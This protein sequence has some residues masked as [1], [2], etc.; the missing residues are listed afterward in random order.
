MSQPTIEDLVGAYLADVY[1]YALRLTGN[2]A[3]AE[4]LTQQTF[5]TAQEKLPQLRDA[6]AARPWLWS[7]ARRGFLADRRRKAPV[8]AADLSEEPDRST[9]DVSAAFPVDREALERALAQ[10][11]D[12]QRLMLARFYF[13]EASYRE[14]AAECGTPLG[15]V[16]SRLAR[17]KRRLRKLLL[18]ETPASPENSR[19]E[20]GAAWT[21]PKPMAPAS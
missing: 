5:L 8:L 13:E 11:P 10:L 6:G 21:D 9:A 4:D 2:P 16:M 17:A 12:E 7:I 19:A 15:T 1:G 20:P 18:P 14:I 3:D